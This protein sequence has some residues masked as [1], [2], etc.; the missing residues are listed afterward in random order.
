MSSEIKAPTILINVTKPFGLEMSWNITLPPS[1][2]LATGNKR[3]HCCVVVLAVHPNESTKLVIST[4]ESLPD[5]CM[6]KRTHVM[7]SDS[8]ELI[9]TG[10]GK[11]NSIER[12]HLEDGGSGSHADGVMDDAARFSDIFDKHQEKVYAASTASG[13]A[14]M[15]V[16]ATAN[17]GQRLLLPPTLAPPKTLPPTDD[18]PD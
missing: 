6:V 12:Y 8:H 5:T 9:E 18:I 3:D 10:I 17:G 2:W 7:S 1:Q 15:D 16:I 13:F 11:S 14:P 4:S